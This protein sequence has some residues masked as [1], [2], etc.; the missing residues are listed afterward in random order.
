MPAA[1]DTVKAI[2][3]GALGKE[4]GERP[5]FLDSACGGDDDLRRRVEALLQAAEAADPLLDRPAAWHLELSPSTPPL[6]T[7]LP[8]EAGYPNAPGL[9]RAGRFRLLGEIARGGMGAILRAHDPEM[10]RAVAVKVALPQYQ[11]DTSL[12]RRFL[13][14]ARLAGQL[15]HPGVVPVYDLGRL[16]DGRP[17]FAM[18]LIEG[19]TLA[20]LLRDRP[21][22]GH[23]LPR[24]LRYFEAVCQTVGYAHSKGVIH[25]DL[26]PSN[27][28]VGAFGEVQVMDWGLAK[29]LPSSGLTRSASARAT[30]ARSA[31]EGIQTPSASEATEIRNPSPGPSPTRS[32][33]AGPSQARSASAGSAPNA[34]AA[35]GDRGEEA[36]TRPG[37]ALGT[38][39]YV[40]PEQASGEV[41]RLDQRS[42]VFGLGA[43]LCEVLT[44]QPPYV[45]KDL[46]QV[47]RQAA[48]ADLAEARARLERSGAD[49]E[50]VG[51]ALSC[52]APEPA[53]R[54]RDG[55]AV[56][57]EV[58]AYLDGV[59]ARL[60]QAELAGA[61]ARA[62]AAGEAKRRRLALALS[63]T[64]LLAVAASAGTALWLHAD[65]QARQAQVTLEVND[66]LNQV[67]SLRDQARTQAADSAA[68][69]A[70]AREQ[71]RRA[72]TLVQS[73]PADA[74]LTARVRRLQR[75]LDEEE[76]DRR[77]VA[78]IEAARL[79]QAETMTGVNAFA[80]LRGLPHFRKAFRTYGLA[81]G[82]GDPAAAAARLGQRPPLV[83]EAAA[84]ALINWIS[85]ATHPRNP[86]PEPHLGWLKAL[87]AAWP[88]ERGG[89]RQIFA[90]WREKDPGKRRAAL[91]QL[92]AEVNVAQMSP[93]ILTLLADWL[94]AAGSPRKAEQ[95]LRRTRQEYPD[96]FWANHDLGLYLVEE[97]PLRWAE[98][99]RYLTAAVALRPKSPGVLL[100]LGHAL[101]QGHQYDEAIACYQKAVALDPEYA[102]AYADLGTAF[103]RKGQVEEAIACFKKGVA[104]RP[105]LSG[106]HN[107]LGAILWDVKRD[108]EGARACFKKAVETDP[109]NAQ[110]YQNLGKVLR[111][112]GRIDE[113]IVSYRKAV[114]IDPRNASYHMDLGITLATKGRVEEAVAC[115]RKAAELDP[116]LSI[117]HNNLGA[118]LCDVKRDYEGAMACFIKAVD[119]DPRLA[120]A[121]GNLGKVLHARGRIDEAIASYRKAIEID[122]RFASAHNGL[123]L[124]LRAKGRMEEAIACHRKAIE[125]DPRFAS[126]YNNLAVCL[127]DQEKVEEAIT[128]YREAIEFDPKFVKAYYNLGNALADK[129]RMDEAIACHKKAIE[130]A[131]AYAE[132]HCNLGNDLKERGDFAPAL[133]ALKRGHE[134]GARRADWNY[135]SAQW[136]RDC[137]QLVGKENQLLKILA[138]KSA[139]ANARER[140]GWAELCIRTRRYVAA[141]RLLG[142]AFNAEPRLADDLKAG[143]RYQAARAAALA[144]AGKDRDAGR[145]DDG[146]T[147]DLRK[148]ALGWLKAE[149]AA[150]ARQPAGEQ[151]AGL[152]HWLA[153]EGLAGVRGGP[154]LPATER[155]SW[156]AFWSE[157]HKHSGEQGKP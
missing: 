35:I 34:P 55:R 157:V 13:G 135:P 46:L 122:P 42:D 114:E 147:A 142:E 16:E 29:I 54:P 149:L 151:A 20:Q 30:Q 154:A 59:Q 75:E 63:G 7:P 25:R 103:F 138:G 47:H 24:F 36:R 18:K 133:A 33:S 105:K 3:Y 60:R 123:G 50:L 37:S 23:E 92:A 21:D 102:N 19:R 70:Q 120:L 125:I 53:D 112:R 27:I 43:I 118:I 143:S 8:A 130:L 26:K 12:T 22:P 80:S 134:L 79:A 41:D 96:D 5:T 117:A 57:G 1:P 32:A 131:P 61:E 82:E 89:V 87:T 6:D 76:R 98:A 49:A 140:L 69:Y 17:F 45:G 40:A 128:A 119:A 71:A 139:P 14:E 145:L 39:A 11:G 124:A 77:F 101:K 4:L 116:K 85:L 2:F 132:A 94:R 56:A 64:V 68:L 44:G 95:L 74:A 136:V 111:A 90:V 15:Q 150:R 99:A 109:R 84:A 66:A 110:A 78:A 28:M 67:T 107:N 152:R 72:L 31:S 146:Q 126:A 93:K 38:P 52:L 65:H 97:E 115:Y 88:D 121:H 62:R 104:L 91:E 137:E 144:A 129:G 10:D 127:R 51:L 155:A 81:A 148:R 9:T 141:V 156:R 106:V 73:G 86:S 100:N 113:A 48:C 153:D 83:R 108:Y 58:T